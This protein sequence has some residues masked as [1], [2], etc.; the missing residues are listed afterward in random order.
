[1]RTIQPFKL[2]LILLV[3]LFGCLFSQMSVLAQSYEIAP[4]TGTPWRYTESDVTDGNWTAIIYNDSAWLVGPSGFSYET[5]AN[6]VTH[7]QTNPSATLVRTALSNPANDPQTPTD[8]RRHARYFRKTFVWT[9]GTANTIINLHMRWDDSG[10]VYL[11]GQVVYNNTGAAPPLGY[12]QYTR[13]AIG[14]GTE[15]IVWEDGS[16]DI[17]AILQPGTNVLAAEVHQVNNGS[18]DIVFVCGATILSPYGPT[19]TDASQP[20]DRVVLQS[21]PTTMTISAVG[22]PDPTYQWYHDGIAID[23]TVNSTATNASYVVSHMSAA[24]AGNYYVVVTGLLGSV[25][26]RT[27]TVGYTADTVAPQ[28]LRVVGSPGFN[29]ITVEF[30]EEMDPQTATDA[31]NY[32]LSPPLNVLSAVLAPGG[33]SVVLTTDAQTPGA[34]Y[35]V[36]AGDVYDYAINHVGSPNS[37]QLNA[38]ISSSCAGVLFEAFNSG[39]STIQFFTNSVNYPNN[40]FTNVLISHFHSRAAF[41]D[42]AHEYYGGRMRA[43]F[44]PQVSGNWRFFMSSDD[45]GELYLNPAGTSPSGR[46]RIAF[47]TACCNIYQPPGAIQTSAAFPMTAGQGY[48]LE[49]IYKEITGGDYGM[50]A[51]HIDGAGIPFGG[52]D[53]GAETTSESISGVTPS[54]FCTVGNLTG[55]PAGVAGTLSITQNLVNKSAQVGNKATFTVGASAPN[56]PFICYRWQK[57]DDGGATFNDIP[58]ATGSSHTTDFLSASDNQDVYRVVVGIPGAEVTS[59]NSVLTVGADATRPKITAVVAVSASALAVYYSEPM[60]GTAA[61]DPFGYE[62]DGGITVGSAAVSSSNPLRI[63]LTVSASTPM[64]PGTLYELTA[65]T[66]FTQVTDPAGNPLD[67]DPTKV[68]FRAIQSFTGNLDAT[69]VLPTNTKL[70]LGSLTDRG[71]NG[72]M[73]QHA[74]PVFHSIDGVTE[75]MLAGTYINPATGLPYPNTAPQPNFVETTII[76]YNNDLVNP[77]VS[78]GHINGDVNFPGY[79]TPQD[80]FCF[81][82][83]TYLELSAGVYHMGVSSDDGFRVTPAT[84]RSDP[85]RSIVLGEYDLAGGRG[86]ADT[87]FDFIAPEDG[88]YPMRLLW[89]EGGGA[90]NVEWWIQSLNDG[91]YIPINDDRIKAFRA[92]PIG[93][94]A[95]TR[96]SGNITLSWFDPTAAFQLQ[97]SPSLTTPV[98]SNVSGATGVG[99]NYSLTVTLPAAGQRYYRLR[100]P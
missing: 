41:P 73:V 45:P 44:I 75:P 58:G 70:P 7:I 29:Q 11:N 21:R 12:V 19:I 91:S 46:I 8:I 72:H 35:T 64:T 89:E 83:L 59:A 5:G 98:W 87:T 14:A 69:P 65:S 32:V 77:P 51:A 31:V 61:E 84:G 80:M 79:T 25:N 6:D 4:P 34:I 82:V 81:E 3:T 74:A 26:S 68:K 17:S 96:G 63:D 71:F 85:N 62:M 56:S 37:G 97:S 67:P 55:A 15:G 16:M 39:A 23:S 20:T 40:P 50:V 13:G 48:Y 93:R 27:N 86:V 2:L 38:W 99:G 53:Q 47:E 30:N 24:D 94:I 95:V 54:P 100:S 60:A 52:N 66:T 76:N 49:L 57:S 33:Y 10:V 28:V 9:N 88:L 18:S 43:V 22:F 42:N 36:S 78:V 92:A 90:A 1:M